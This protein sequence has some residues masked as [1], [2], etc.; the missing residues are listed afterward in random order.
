[1]SS[2]SAAAVAANVS[3]GFRVFRAQWPVVPLVVGRLIPDVTRALVYAL[4]GFAVGGQAG[5]EF[6]IVGSVMLTALTSVLAEATDI[7]VSDV[8]FRTY[9]AVSLS[10][11]APF[12]QY[13]ARSVV[14]W[15]AGLITCAVSAVTV[16][17]VTGHAEL[18]LPLLV[19]IPMLIPAMIGATVLG[20]VVIAP[21]IGSAWEGITYNAAI[22]ILTVCSGAIFSLAAP[23]FQVVA[24]L[25]PLTHS[26]NAVRA[27]LSGDPW[28][29]EIGWECAVALL[30]SA[31]ALGIYVVQD[32]R[33]RRRG[34]GAF[35]N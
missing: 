32:R 4:I 17:A 3:L 1:M 5:L 22:A 8:N 33:G 6:A 30:W 35:V 16:C 7:P 23:G 25:L 12:V 27:S 9:P 18:I 31:I 11:V 29:A 34:T 21:A 2:P 28:L 14:L 13:V 20:L 24:G 10:R 19:R 15:C 26:L